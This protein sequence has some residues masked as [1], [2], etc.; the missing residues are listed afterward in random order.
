MPDVLLKQAK[1]TVKA[2]LY[3]SLN[4]FL[5]ASAR[6]EL[7]KRMEPPAVAEVRK[8]REEMDREYLEKAGGDREKMFEL[9]SEDLRDLHLRW[10]QYFKSKAPANSR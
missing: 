5:V 8:A 7:F 2:G 4:E 9:I 10:P 6:N 1:R 3:P